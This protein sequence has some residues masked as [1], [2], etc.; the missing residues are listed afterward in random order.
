MSYSSKGDGIYQDSRTGNLYHRPRINGVRTFRKLRSTT[1]TMARKE[2]AILRTRQMEAKVGLAVD[3][4]AALLTVG[5]I[6]KEWLARGCP[7]KKGHPRK[8]PALE[9]EQWRLSNLLPFWKDR[10]AATI[11]P[12]D[13]RDY[14]AWRKRTRKKQTVTMDRSVDMEL[15]TLSNL[16]NWAKDNPRKTGL[17][18]NQ[19]QYRPRFQDSKSIRHCS[20]VMPMNDEVFHQLAEYLLSDPASQKL[21]WQMLLEALCM[22][23]TNE[24][25]HC[26]VDAR[27]LTNGEAEPGY[28]TDRILYLNRLKR[29]MNP[30]AL[31]ELRPGFSPLRE[32]L[33]AFR[34]WH[35]KRYAKS[36]SPW[37]IPGRDPSRPADAGSLTHALTRACEKLG[38]PHVTSHGMIAYGVRVHRAQGIDDSE[39]SKRRGLRSG[40]AMIERKYGICEPGWFASRALDFLPDGQEPAWARWLPKPNRK[41]V[42]LSA[43]HPHT[44]SGPTG[45]NPGKSESGTT[46]R[47]KARKHCEI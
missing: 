33:E 37:F 7:D 1:L 41:I 10:E 16:F 14:H 15:I 12:E 40:V 38:L 24:I 32:C 36:K 45:S 21:G 47:P 42:D 4:Y 44:N 13:C 9:S 3:P 2:V 34:N 28:Q 11:T 22:A 43:Y 19:I 25:L 23:R 26:R 6:A 18:R 27:M 8:G 17:L 29:G 31:L 30:W 5:Q 46:P 35:K 20:A 39:I